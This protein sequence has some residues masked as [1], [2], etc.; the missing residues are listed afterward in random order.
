MPQAALIEEVA[1][2]FYTASV[3]EWRLRL[4]DID[5]CFEALFGADKIT[6]LAQFQSRKALSIAGPTYPA[7]IDQEAVETATDFE[8]IEPGA[9]PAWNT[10]PG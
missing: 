6:Q 8:E 10:G 7:W 1:A 2:I 3:D 5:C 4:D 9:K